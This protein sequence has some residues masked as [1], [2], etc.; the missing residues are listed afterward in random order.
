MVSL[1]L[2]EGRLLVNGQAILR[3][4]PEY[5]QHPT[6]QHL[7][8]KKVFKIGPSTKAHMEFTA[9]Q[10]QE[11]WVIHF[12]LKKGHLIV[13]ARKNGLTWEFIPPEVLKGDFP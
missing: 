5:Y 11:V 3:L 8:G 13:Q 10:E 2:F 12:A 6:Y 1:D 9:S 7:F 4:P